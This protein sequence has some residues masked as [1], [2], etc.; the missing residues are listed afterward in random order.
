MSQFSNNE[1]LETE[2]CC[3]CGMSFAMTVD[4]RKR[5]IDDH[6]MFWCPAG[7]QQHYTGE[8]EAQKLKIELERQKQIIDATQARA[9]KAEIEREQ[10]SRAHKK[11]RTRVMNGVCPCC[12]RTFQ[13]LLMHMKSEH[14]E[15]RETMKLSTLRAAFGMS[16]TAVAKEA[17]VNNAYVSLYEREHPVPDYAKSRL[18]NWVEK[19]NN[20]GT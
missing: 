9:N 12:N 11:M 15:F 6:K 3:S 10:I 17:G 20:K 19:H 1:W 8:T 14:P 18:D 4:F 5:R 2:Q 13:N 7:H 16:Q